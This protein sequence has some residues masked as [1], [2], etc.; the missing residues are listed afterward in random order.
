MSGAGKLGIELCYAQMSIKFTNEPPR[1]MKA[2]LRRT[3]SGLTHD[4]LDVCNSPQW[5]SLL[6][7]VAFLHS[8]VQERRTYGPLGWNIPYEFNVADFH[9]SVQFIQNHLDDMDPRKVRHELHG[10]Q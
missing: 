6:F 5:K 3:Y 4:Q 10:L 7:A 2:G 8:T 1:G 9:A